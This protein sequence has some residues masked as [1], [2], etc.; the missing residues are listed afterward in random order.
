MA[1]RYFY[2]IIEAAATNWPDQVSFRRRMPDNK[3]SGRSYRELKVLVDRLTAGFIAE[4]IAVG[5]RVTYLCDASTNWII[6]DCA[7]VSCGAVSV[8]RG[9]D[10]TDEDINYILSHS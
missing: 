10:V 7:I 5:D 3:L 2:D 1:T 8:P 4:G 6:G 9:T